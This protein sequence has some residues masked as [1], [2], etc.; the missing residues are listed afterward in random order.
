MTTDSLLK[1]LEDR[2]QDITRPFE[3]RLVDTAVWFHKNKDR[4]PR[5][6]LKARIDFLET[7]LDIFIELTAMS[8]DRLH[9]VEG[10]GKS[11]LWLP[12]GM[13]M[14]GSVKNFG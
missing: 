7:A 3:R 13:A 10:R 2:A 4:M 6:N 1:E 14:S 11:K 5:E 9:E 8:M 12:T